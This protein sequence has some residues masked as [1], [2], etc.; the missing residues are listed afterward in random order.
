MIGRYPTS[1]SIGG[2]DYEIDTDFKVGIAILNEFNNSGSSTGQKTEFMLRML[3]GEKGF[4]SLAGKGEA[5]EKAGWYLR[6]GRKEKDYDPSYKGISL[7]AMVFDWEQDGHLI[8]AGIAKH[9]GDIRQREHCHFWEFMAYFSEMGECTFTTVCSIRSKRARG[10]KL[11]K[12][13]SE[14]YNRNRDLVELELATR[15]KVDAFSEF[16]GTG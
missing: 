2:T 14:F 7:D 4:R 16:F 12:W 15:R 13:E 10:K 1:L 9:R 11:E 8:F 6:C 5:I 3:F